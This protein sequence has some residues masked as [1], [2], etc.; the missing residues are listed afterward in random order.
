[1]IKDLELVTYGERLRELESFSLEKRSLRLILSVQ[2]YVGGA[3]K[4]AELDSVVP[5]VKMQ[6]A[7]LEI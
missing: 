5:N 2:K 7:Q 4:K 3:F 6:W 1:M